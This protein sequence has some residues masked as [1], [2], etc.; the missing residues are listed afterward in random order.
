MA[1]TTSQVN[2]MLDNNF[3]SNTWLALFTT[4]PTAAGSGTEAS[5][6]SYARQEITFGTAT[7][8]SISSLNDITF[9]VNSGTYTYYGI[10]SAATGGTMKDYGRLIPGSAIVVSVDDSNINVSSGDITVTISTSI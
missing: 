10:M 5:G 6:G 4:N 8:A 9:T 1:L 7:G 2:T 3:S